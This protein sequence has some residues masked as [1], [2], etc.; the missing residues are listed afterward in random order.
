VVAIGNYKAVARATGKPVAAEWVMV[1]KMRGGKV[2]YFR[3]YTDTQALAA[4]V[5]GHAAANIS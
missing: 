2:I 4:A 3:E 1:W 5:T